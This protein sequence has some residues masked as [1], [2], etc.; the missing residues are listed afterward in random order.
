VDSP[1]TFCTATIDWFCILFLRAPPCVHSLSGQVCHIRPSQG[2]E[3]KAKLDEEPFSC[4]RHGTGPIF[5]PNVNFVL[6]VSVSRNKP[7]HSLFDP[8]PSHA[9]AESGQYRPGRVFT[10]L[11]FVCVALAS[12]GVAR[13]TRARH[14]RGRARQLVDAPATF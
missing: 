2:R 6:S 13:E 14:C 7:W 1:S 5:P 12:T 11:R 8:T 3:K 9:G 10:V 4:M